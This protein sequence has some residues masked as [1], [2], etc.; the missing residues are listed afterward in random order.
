MISSQEGTDDRR[1]RPPAAFLAGRSRAGAGGCAVLSSSAVASPLAVRTSV[2]IPAERAGTSRLAGW[3]GLS[4]PAERAGTSRLAGC[5][6]GCP[7]RRSAPDVPACRAGLCDVPAAAPVRLGQRSGGGGP[8]GASLVAMGVTVA[9]APAPVL[10]GGPGMSPSGSDSRAAS[11]SAGV[12][13]LRC[14]SKTHSAMCGRPP[15]VNMSCT[16]H[17]PSARLRESH[18]ASSGLA[19]NVTRRSV[20]ISPSRG[21]GPESPGARIVRSLRLLRPVR[22]FREH[23]ALETAHTLDRHAGRVRDLIRCLS[24]TDP[25]LDLLGSQG[26]LHFD[27]VLSEPGELPARHDPQPVVDRQ[28]KAPATSWHRENGVAAIL[29]HRDEAQFLHRRPF[30]AAD[31]VGG[32]D[33]ARGRSSDFPLR[34]VCRV[35]ATSGQHRAGMSRRTPHTIAAGQAWRREPG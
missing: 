33:A 20:T 4:I 2:S 3:A 19:P 23:G 16:C 7:F 29:T 15:A 32:R 9:R 31:V 22:P 25:V 17:L 35:R 24:G 13:C 30:C 28:G 27:L 6:P 21:P 8:S 1:E 12:A 5:R 18:S 10:R 14:G 11:S 34:R 26:T